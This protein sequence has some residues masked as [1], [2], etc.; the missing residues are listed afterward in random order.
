MKNKVIIKGNKVYIHEIHEIHENLE[1][2]LK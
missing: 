1:E 2:A